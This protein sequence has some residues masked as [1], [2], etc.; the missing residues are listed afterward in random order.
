MATGFSNGARNAEYVIPVE[1][2]IVSYRGRASTF[3][4][5]GRAAAGQKILAIHNAAASPVLV[6]VRQV[7]VDML[8]TVVKAVTVVPPTIRLHRFTVLPTNGTALGK[9]PFDTAVASNAAVTAWGDASA[10]N[11][12][13]VTTL[14]VTVPANSCLAQIAGPRILT[15][16]GQ[17]AIDTA[18]FFEAGTPPILLRALEGL[19]VFLDAAVVTTGNPATDLWTASLEWTEYTRP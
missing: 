7:R 2:K 17:E 8:S 12:T 6:D 3:I 15:A 1:D 13:S 16:V 10:D 19:V 4:T 5:P 18:A 9:V 11:V 14:T